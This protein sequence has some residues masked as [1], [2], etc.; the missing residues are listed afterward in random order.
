MARCDLEQTLMRILKTGAQ[1]ATHGRSVTDSVLS[2][3]IQGMP[4]AYDIMDQFE[5]FTNSR[6]TPDQ[7]VDITSTHQKKDKQDIQSFKIWLTEHGL[8]DERHNKLMSLSTGLVG[9]STVDCH[10]AVEKGLL[11]DEIKQAGERI[12]LKLFGADCDSIDQC[13]V[14]KF[15]V[16]I[17][18]SKTVNLV[19]LPPTVA[20][21]HQHCLRVYYQV[22]TWLDQNIAFD[23]IIKCVKNKKGSLFLLDAPGG[24]GKTFLTHL[25]LAKVRQSGRKA[26]AIASGIA[27]TLLNGGKTAQS[28]FELP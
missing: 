12:M 22:Q 13:R 5:S 8:F 1:S 24:I 14:D 27:T 26:R 28:T 23:A 25:L 6:C 20:A 17:T 11:T 10:K 7:H 3:F 2:R 15:S 16:C 18:K 21:T 4:Y 19:T 9:D